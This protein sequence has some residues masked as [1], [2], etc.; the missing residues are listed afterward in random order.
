MNRRKMQLDICRALLNPQKKLFGARIGK[1]EYAVTNGYIAYIF[2]CDEC[3]FDVS[4]I[5][6]HDQ[7]I[8][9]LSQ[10]E[11]D[12]E[13]TKTGNLYVKYGVDVEFE[14]GDFKIYANLDYVKKF[15]G[16]HLFAYSPS[17]RVLA[18]DDFG[19]TVGCFMPLRWG[20]TGNGNG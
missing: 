14:A 11:K 2:G 17:S 13:L 7:L 1:D 5:A 6:H 4:R 12:V 10:D 9:V 20:D 19:K 18:K 8:S 16:Y 15:D 3:V